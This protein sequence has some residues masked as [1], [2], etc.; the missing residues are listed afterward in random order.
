MAEVGGWASRL[1]VEPQRVYV[2][3]MK[4]KWASCT[5]SGR[6]YFSSDLIGE[7]P[8]FR[9]V[10]IVHELLH[11][12]IRNHGKLFKGLLNAFVPGWER[13]IEGKAN[14]ICR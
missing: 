8:E 13:K 12:R 5:P 6:L 11:L 4:K 10:V 2:Q 3:S 14:R 1:R 9:E 7:A